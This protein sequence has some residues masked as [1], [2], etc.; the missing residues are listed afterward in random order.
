M[1]KQED[2]YFVNKKKILKQE[3]EKEWM[4]KRLE[5]QVKNR[6]MINIL[7]SFFEPSASKSILSLKS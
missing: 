7:I 2:L 6:L 5:F 3:I 4:S 1:N